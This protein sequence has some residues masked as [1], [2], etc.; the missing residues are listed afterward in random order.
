MLLACQ[1]NEIDEEIKL[2]AC[3]GGCNTPRHAQKDLF[4]FWSIGAYCNRTKYIE[5]DEEIKLLKSRG[6]LHPTHFSEASVGADAIRPDASVNQIFNY[7]MEQIFL[8]QSQFFALRTHSSQKTKEEKTNSIS[9]KLTTHD[10]RLTTHGIT[11]HGITTHHSLLTTHSYLS[12]S[13]GSSLAAFNA[14]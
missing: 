14:G 10:S 7:L 3:R 1:Y 13:I 4:I 5:I 8:S 12:D 2:L 9:K 6:V 11:T